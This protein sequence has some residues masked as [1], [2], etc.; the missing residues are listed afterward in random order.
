MN[1]GAAT[2][3]LPP[4]QPDCAPPRGRRFPLPTTARS[5]LIGAAPAAGF[6]MDRVSLMLA[7][8]IG[9]A[10]AGCAVAASPQTA[11]TPLTSVGELGGS[12][13]GW[14]TYG[15]IAFRVNV[16]VKPDGT[17]V[18]AFANNPAH[19]VVLVLEGGNLRFGSDPQRLCCAARFFEHGR[20]QYLTF[21]TTSGGVWVECQ[22]DR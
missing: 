9:T 8:F 7:L 17:A 11:T 22:R 1:L 21:F 5:A 4:V 12:W 10:L 3:Q 15:G 19:H 14:H 6:T 2:A 16:H 20:R 13:S 18:L